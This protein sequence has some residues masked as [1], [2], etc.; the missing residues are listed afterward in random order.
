MYTF[1]LVVWIKKIWNSD[2]TCG[3]ILLP[4]VPSLQVNSVLPSNAQWNRK[5]DQ[6][7]EGYKKMTILSAS[8]LIMNL[9]RLLINSENLEIKLFPSEQKLS[10][11]E[12]LSNEAATVVESSAWSVGLKC[13]WKKCTKISTC[14]ID[15]SL[16]YL[17]KRQWFEQ[18]TLTFFLIDID[19]GWSNVPKMQDNQI[20]KSR[21]DSDGERLWPCTLR[22]L[23]RTSLR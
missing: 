7:K 17:W 3:I 5:L 10:S 13:G 18:S 9:L 1:I 23:C 6:G 20:P 16:L 14:S 12:M 21:H 4:F 19:N 2:S 8:H 15:D 22:V 11:R